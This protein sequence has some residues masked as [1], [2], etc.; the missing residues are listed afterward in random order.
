MLLAFQDVIK[1]KYA[2]EK[3]STC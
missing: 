1:V 3:Y 2:K